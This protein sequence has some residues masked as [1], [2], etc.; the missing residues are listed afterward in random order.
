MA[1]SG[2]FKS[3]YSYNCYVAALFYRKFETMFNTRIHVYIHCGAL[4]ISD[5]INISTAN[6]ISWDGFNLTKRDNVPLIISYYVTEE[7]VQ[8]K[9]YT[10]LAG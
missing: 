3:S 7:L 1:V 2:F 8:I 9:N 4:L 5:W 10:K 6:N